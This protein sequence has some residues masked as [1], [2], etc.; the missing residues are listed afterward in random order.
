[1]G[2]LITLPAAIIF[3]GAATSDFAGSTFSL[4]VHAM[5]IVF[6]QMPAGRLFGFLWLFMLFV[7]AVTSSVSMLQPVIAFLEEGFALKRHASAA[8]LGLV[9]AIG[10]GYV[11]YFSKGL[12]ALDTFDFWVG[13]FL[14]FVLAMV[15]ALL[16][17]WVFGIVKGDEELHRGAHIR[18]PRFVQFVLKYI[19]PVYLLGIFVIFC[20]QKLPSWELEKFRTT[21]GQPTAL[22]AGVLPEPFLAAFTAKGLDVPEDARIVR[23]AQSWTI[24][25]QD[26]TL[27]YRVVADGEEWVVSAP[28]PGY[29]ETVGKNPVALNS[30]LFVALIFT[31]VLILIHIAGRRWAAEGRFTKLGDAT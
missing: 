29:L 14:I 20:V 4:G 15:Q 5:P 2:G 24:L 31:F 7:A 10:C 11:M 16:Y 6:A 9:S 1:L 13:S 12:V 26:D 3:L 23:D 30:V 21:A 8:I 19:V 17:G 22:D 18:I 27:A 25:N 28:S